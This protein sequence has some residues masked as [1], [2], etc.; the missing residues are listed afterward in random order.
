MTAMSWCGVLLQLRN[1]ATI[2]TSIFERGGQGMVVSM[3]CTWSFVICIESA[4]LRQWILLV[5]GLVKECIYYASPPC[6][7]QYDIVRRSEM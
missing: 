4:V 1:N 3:S 7:C 5:L 2:R 6:S